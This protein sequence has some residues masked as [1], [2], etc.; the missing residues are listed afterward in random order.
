VS[1]REQAADEAQGHGA[2]RITR[3]SCTDPAEIVEA[4]HSKHRDSPG[5]HQMTW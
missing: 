3:R 4:Y 1:A 5:P 2:M